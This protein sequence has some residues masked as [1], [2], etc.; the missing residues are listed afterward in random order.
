MNVKPALSEIQKEKIEKSKKTVFPIVIKL[1][2]EKKIVI[3]ADEAVFSAGQI[4][5]KIWYV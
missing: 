2:K 1:V 3:F 5:P 4:K